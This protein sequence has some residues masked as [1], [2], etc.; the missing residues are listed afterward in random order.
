MIQITAHMRI[1]VAVEP[2]D[3]R[4]GIDGLCAVCRQEL[5]MDPFSGT[6][7]VF[8][9]K[10]RQALR[11]L[12]YDGQGFW[13]CHKRLSRGR[14]AWNFPSP[15]SRT[16]GLLARQLQL[17]LWNAD[18]LKISQGEDFRPITEKNVDTEKKYW[19]RAKSFAI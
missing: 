5:D 17:L 1:M 4:K 13:L 15:Q 6:L 2:V 7:F 9:N 3:F 11:V 16:C 18:P 12:V 14:F 19:P 8:V 10:S